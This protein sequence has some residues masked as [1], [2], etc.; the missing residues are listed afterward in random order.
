[1]GSNPIHPAVFKKSA[2]PSDFKRVLKHSLLKE[3]QE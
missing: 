3:R 2:E 1:M